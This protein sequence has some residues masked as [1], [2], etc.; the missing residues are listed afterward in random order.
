MGFIIE[1]IIEKIGLKNPEHASKLLKN[2]AGLEDE[3]Y[4]ASEAFFQRYYAYLANEGKTIDFGVDCYLHMCDDMIEQR[5]KFI[6]TGKYTSTSFD[7]VENRVYGND[8][9]MT[10][11]MH[12]LV[13]GQFLWFEQYERFKFFKENL[14]N[15]FPEQGKYL[16]IGGGHGLYMLGAL[17]I[18]PTDTV[19]DLVDISQSSINLAKGIID[20]S[21]VN[22][23]L[24]NVFD[25]DDGEQYDFFTMGEVLEHLEDPI[26]I[27]KKLANLIG[28]TGKGYITT[29]I[30]S[31][32][33]DHIYLFNNEN[34]IRE[35]FDKAG[36][37]ILQ[38]KSVISEHISPKLANKFKVPIMYAA[39]IEQKNKI[40]MEE[41]EILSQVVEIFKDELDNEEIQLTM[42]STAKDIEDWDS[43]SHIHLMVAIEKHFKIRFTSSEISNFKNVGE[44]V[45]TVKK[46]LG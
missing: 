21:R 31:P 39:F 5:H 44:M 18:L 32:M 16:E 46:R 34:D 20:D 9:I 10:Y 36:L 35:V 14:K 45:E 41:Q 7:E 22:F 37:S 24:K 26:A 2:L 29:P 42:D 8:T 1:E 38:E 40:I 15:Y 33:I 12:G 4:P 6:E 28:P 3:I 30:N 43:L 19:F 13:L 11:H 23:T 27:L 25:I 17:D